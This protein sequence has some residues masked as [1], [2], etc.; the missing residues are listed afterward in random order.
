MLEKIIRKYYD[1]IFRY[2]W[3]HV[4]NKETAEDLCQDTFISFI[5]HYD[6]FRQIGKTKNYLYTIAGNKCKDYYKK[7]VPLLLETL[8][9]Q[10]DKINIEENVI[11]RQM[12]ME[13]SAELKEVITLRY[14]QNLKYAD[15]ALILGISQSLVKYRVKKALEQ[16]AEMEGGQY[17]NK[18]S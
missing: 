1:E 17:D 15:I 12:I 18:G 11:M 10:V 6:N 13:L 2:C 5:E 8:P 9:E 7:K 16:L 4:G 14:L 3:H